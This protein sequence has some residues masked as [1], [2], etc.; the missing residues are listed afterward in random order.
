ML[1]NDNDNPTFFQNLLDQILSFER[2]E[3]IIRGDFD[4][5]MDVQKR[6]K[7]EETR[8]RIENRLKK[9]RT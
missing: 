7:K 3:I 2:E 5:V 6:V 4:L 9:Y 8:Q 1:D